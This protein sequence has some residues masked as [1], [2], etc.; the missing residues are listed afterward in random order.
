MDTERRV[1]RTDSGEQKRKMVKVSMEIRSGAARFRVGVQARTIREALSLLGG[2]YVRGTVR[3]V[4]PLEQK[5]FLVDE[6]PALARMP[7]SGHIHAEAA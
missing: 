6:Q 5:G 1:A 3:A 7:G 4:L 2:R